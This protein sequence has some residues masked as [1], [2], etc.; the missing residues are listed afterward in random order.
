MNSKTR[1]PV[2][3]YQEFIARKAAA[4]TVNAEAANFT[5][6]APTGA[7]PFEWSPEQKAELMQAFAL[8]DSLERKADNEH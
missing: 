5:I 1:Q 8:V 6:S 2:C 4:G 3:D 7:K